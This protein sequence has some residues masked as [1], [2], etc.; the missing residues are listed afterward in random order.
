MSKFNIHS[1]FILLISCFVGNSLF[2]QAPDAM[3]YQAIVRD[4]AGATLINQ[5]VGFEAMVHQGTPTG[6]VVYQESV[7]LTTNAIGLIT[8]NIGEANL[9][10]F[11]TI[12]WENGPY[13][14]ETK[15]DPNGGSN[16]TIQ[17]TSQLFSVP[18]ALYANRSLLSDSAKFATEAAYVSQVGFANSAQVAVFSDTAFFAFQAA[19]ADLANHSFSSDSSDH[20]DRAVLADHAFFADSAGHA[21][22]AHLSNHAFSSDSAGHANLADFALFADSANF[23]DQSRLTDHANTADSSDHADLADLAGHAQ[24]SDSSDHADLAEGAFLAD[25][26]ITSDTSLHAFT[27]DHALSSNMAGFATLAAQAINSD[28]ANHASTSDLAVSAISANQATTA[29]F[30]AFADSSNYA[31]STHHA[32]YSDTAQFAYNNY[33]DYAVFEHQMN[34]GLNGPNMNSNS[35]LTRILNTTVTNSGNSIGLVGNTI[36]LQP[37]KYEIRATA[38]I[39][40]TRRCQIRLYDQTNSA[41]ILLGTSGYGNSDNENVWSSIDGYVEVLNP[42]NFL[43]QSND[44]SSNYWGRASNRGEHEVFARIVIHKIQ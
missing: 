40:D 21:V 30:S 15:I 11:G 24:T 38:T 14:L 16:Y 28:S 2:G 4:A 31:D 8:R 29:N 35:W 41:T 34:N 18:Y 1:F 32:A 5:S 44:D 37:G 39:N 6:T 12:N 36:T 3:K 27:S 25:H 33:G 9:P 10:Q 42:A 17:G 43:L 23:A 22:L 13:F 20:A 7:V 19:Q 26:S